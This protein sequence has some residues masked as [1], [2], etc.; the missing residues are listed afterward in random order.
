MIAGENTQQPGSSGS[1]VQNGIETGI[2][3]IK[4]PPFW[5]GMPKLWFQRI[6]AQFRTN[7]EVV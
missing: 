3:S 7:V 1:S 5:T 6:E 4:L 2:N